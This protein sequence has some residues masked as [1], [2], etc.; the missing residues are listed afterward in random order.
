MVLNLEYPMVVH[1]Y[2]GEFRFTRD[3]GTIQG[4]GE[5]MRHYRVAPPFF[6][7]ITPW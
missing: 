4:S 7:D 2:G 1:R 6:P 5:N 3:A